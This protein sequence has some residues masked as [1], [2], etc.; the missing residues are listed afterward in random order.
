MLI[1]LK[2]TKNQKDFFKKFILDLLWENYT[3]CGATNKSKFDINAINDKI[4]TC[5][6][7][8]LEDFSHVKNLDDYF[9]IN[10][11]YSKIHIENNDTEKLVIILKEMEERNDEE[12][13][14]K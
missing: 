6:S 7:E 14:I 9:G 1:E 5:F 11:Q 12:L 4:N 10:I 2:L 13:N 8:F 3:K